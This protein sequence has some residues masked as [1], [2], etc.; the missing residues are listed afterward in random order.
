MRILWLFKNNLSSYC[1]SVSANQFITTGQSEDNRLKET[2]RNSNDLSNCYYGP[3][4]H[5]PY[6]S[7]Q[8]IATCRD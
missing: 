3:S 7:L 5:P 8:V 6:K 4:G 1:K 2:V